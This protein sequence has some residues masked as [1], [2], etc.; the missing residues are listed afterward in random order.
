MKFLSLLFLILFTVS[1]ATHKFMRGTVAMKVDENTA[2]VCLGDNDVAKGDKVIF[3]KNECVS[4]GGERGGGDGECKLK[5]L[6][7]GKV[8]KVLNSH[9]SH[10]E[11]NG[12]FSFKEGTMVQKK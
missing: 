12:N 4:V 11:T 9:Y 2:H 6:G 7:E 3:F 10:V 5:V 8:K 1:C